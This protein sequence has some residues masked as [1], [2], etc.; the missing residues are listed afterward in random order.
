MVSLSTSMKSCARSREFTGR[1]FFSKC[2]RTRVDDCL[3]IGEQNAPSRLPWRRPARCGAAA[4][5]KQLVEIGRR[6]S[7]VDQLGR[8]CIELRRRTNAAI[9]AAQNEAATTG[10]QMECHSDVRPET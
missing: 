3:R 5:A 4:Q 2:E 7:G 8:R 6:Q 10:V 9:L 1:C